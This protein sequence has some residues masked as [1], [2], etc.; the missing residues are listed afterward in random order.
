MSG[1]SVLQGGLGWPGPPC[2]GHM[3]TGTEISEL[4][5]L[6]VGLQHR[7]QRGS[8]NSSHVETPMFIALGPKNCHMFCP[9]AGNISCTSPTQCIFHDV[10][11]PFPQPQPPT[12]DNPLRPA[13]SPRTEVHQ[14]AGGGTSQSH[15]G[16]GSAAKCSKM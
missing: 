1:W 2:E 5:P 8:G 16:L 9:S 14:D 12:L 6:M 11:L 3:P 7:I 15:L 4:A 10:P 13:A